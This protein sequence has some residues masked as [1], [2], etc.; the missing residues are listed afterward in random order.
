MSAQKDTTNILVTYKLTFQPDS[1]NPASSV[2]ELFSLLIGARNSLHISNNQLKRDEYI[3]QLQENASI[4][5]NLDINFSEVPR[6]RFSSQYVLNKID[7]T[8]S[9]FCNLMTDK[10]FY[11]VDVPMVFYKSVQAD[12]GL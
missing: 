10:Y 9:A 3:E 7:G 5:N 2:S 11:E 6:S 1:T 8:L 12:T 4:G